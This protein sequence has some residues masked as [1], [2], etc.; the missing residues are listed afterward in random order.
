MNPSNESQAQPATPALTDSLSTPGG[1]LRAVR[2]ALSGKEQDYTRGPLTRAI[3]LL[4]IPMVL[5]MMMERRRA[6]PV[7]QADLDVP[8]LV[9]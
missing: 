8:A 6:S 9:E 4:A 2:E 5:E 1:W 3:M 7:A